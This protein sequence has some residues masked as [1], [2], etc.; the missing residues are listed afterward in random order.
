MSDHSLKRTL[1]LSFLLVLA[2]TIASAAT[3]SARYETRMVWDTAIHRAVLFGGSTGIDP[4]TKLAYEL[5]DT[6]EWTGSRWIERFLAH[7]PG[8]RG[9]ESMIFDSLRNRVVIFGGRYQKTNLN[10]TWS[11]DGTDWTQIQTATSPSVRELASAAYD[12]ARDRIVLFGGTHQTYSNDGRT[13]T[14]T[15]LHETYEF[16][17]TNWKQILSDG[18]AVIKS[19]LAYD[20]VRNRTIMIGEDTKNATVMYAWDPVAAKW[21]QLTPTLLPACANEGAMT[22]QSSNNTVLYT[23]GVCTGSAL[24]EDTYEWDGTNWTKID[25]T[26]FAGRFFGSALTFDP[27]HNVAV[28]FGGAPATGALLASTFTYADKLWTSVGDAAYPV[29]RSLAVFTSDP[30]RGVI[31]LF[32]GLNDSTTFYDLW[33]YQNGKFQPQFASNQ[34]GDCSSPIG[35]Y[36]TDR[37]K[38]VVVCEGSAT[39]E[40]DG[41]TWTQF[42]STKVAPPSHKFAS[43]AYDQTLKKIVFFGGYDGISAYLD[44]TWVYDGT[45]WAQAKKNPP[46]QRSHAAMWYDPIL[47]KTVIYGGLGR[48]TSNDRLQRFSDMWSFD[49]LGWTEIKPATTPGMRYGAAV[50]V[51][52]KTN[53]TFVFGGIRVDTDA[54]NNQIQVYANDM[55]EWDGAAWTKVIT[56]LTPPVR[57]N[58]GFAVDPLRNELVLFAGY[59]GFYLSDLWT[60]SNGQWKQVTEVLTR[61]RAAH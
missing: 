25:L 49:G 3:P 28:M 60:F 8:Q 51:D 42:D 41:T 2:A 11:Y 32:G 34:P 45:L 23:G 58:A 12:S 38:L 5:G 59:S 33:F 50:V 18:P 48:L 39:W 22:W 30:A 20:P 54:A 35:A 55:W 10:D 26:L 57:E 6:W 7:S 61:R 16:D 53:H 14:E 43:I 52:P 56:V 9:A 15:P 37:Q 27:D 44:Q 4:G 31:D 46:P 17:G 19:V 36:D 47:K 40:F 21:N 13:L 1:L 24:T 29:P